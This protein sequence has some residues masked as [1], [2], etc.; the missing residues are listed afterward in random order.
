MEPMS[1]PFSFHLLF[2][3]NCVGELGWRY[4][5]LILHLKGLFSVYC[6]DEVRHPETEKNLS[7]TPGTYTTQTTENN[8]NTNNTK[9]R[10]TINLTNKHTPSTP[11]S[12]NSTSNPN[13][14]ININNPH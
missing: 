4:S 14:S 12:T 13:T 9:H 1:N 6:A 8:N 3:G 2:S 5:A 11:T 7:H 10:P